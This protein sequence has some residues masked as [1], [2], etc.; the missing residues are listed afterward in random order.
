MAV[1]VVLALRPRAGAFVQAAA[2]LSGYIAAGRALDALAPSWTATTASNGL[3]DAPVIA[4]A[5]VGTTISAL[6][7]RSPASPPS[8]SPDGPHL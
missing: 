5:V 3:D 1:F 2:V 8:A 6:A 4:G 7:R